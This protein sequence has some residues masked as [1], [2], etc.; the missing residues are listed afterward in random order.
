[1]NE[2]KADID[3]EAYRL[4][5]FSLEVSD[6]PDLLLRRGWVKDLSFALAMKILNDVDAESTQVGGSRVLIGLMDRARRFADCWRPEAV[7]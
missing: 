7:L 4:L 2:E 6:N 1:M 5:M 3:M